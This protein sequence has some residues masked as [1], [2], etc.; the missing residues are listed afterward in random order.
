MVD[1]YLEP[2]GNPKNDRQIRR[3]LG[4][5]RNPLHVFLK[6]L[7]T[8]FFVSALIVGNVIIFHNLYY[9]SFFVNGQSM[10]PTLNGNA[11]YSDGTLVEKTFDYEKTIDGMTVDYGIMDTHE[12]T[13]QGIRRFDIIVTKYSKDDNSDKIKRVIALPGETFYFVSTSP[14]EATNGDLYLIFEGTSE[15]VLIPQTFGSEAILREKDY[16]GSNIPKSDS[17]KTLG[18]DEYYVLG[19]NRP[20]SD[21]SSGGYLIK[22]SFIAGVAIAL[23][24]TCVLACEIGKPCE[25]G[26]VNFSW[27]QSLRW[28][29]A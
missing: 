8:I 23:E 4:V 2:T 12:Y 11:T 20:H 28:K 19:D 15:G 18:D 14:N 17:P 27:P 22:Y 5:K 16:S 29:D 10:Y 25:A 9:R 7:F 3:E 26:R 13:K 1:T 6:V 21:D 24:G